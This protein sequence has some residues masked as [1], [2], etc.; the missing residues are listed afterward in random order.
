MRQEFTLR[1]VAGGYLGQNYRSVSL[2]TWKPNK[3]IVLNNTSNKVYVRRGSP[4]IPSESNADYVVP[5]AS[6]GIPGNVA[7]PANVMEWGLFLPISPALTDDTQVATVIF[8]G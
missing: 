1:G 2:L 6:N 5:A 8:E 3:I 7:L 4:D